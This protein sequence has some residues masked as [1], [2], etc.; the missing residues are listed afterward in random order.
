MKP[1]SIY[2]TSYVL[3]S[4]VLGESK[5]L[6]EFV[7]N[8]D[9]VFGTNSHSLVAV[10]DMLRWLKEIEDCVKNGVIECEEIEEFGTRET[11]LAEVQRVI[12]RIQE[13]PDFVCIDLE[14]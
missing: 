11:V 8:S 6:L 9:F 3:A 5:F 10:G 7:S 13:I 1:L 14:G 4:D 2:T 12:Y